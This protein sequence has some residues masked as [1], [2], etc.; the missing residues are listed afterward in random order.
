MVLHEVQ[1]ATN[2]KVLSLLQR[3][4]YQPA[5]RSPLWHYTQFF[6]AEDQ[7][8]FCFHTKFFEIASLPLLPTQAETFH[9]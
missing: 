8:R 1:N 4:Q 3:E 7:T 2:K 6:L 5:L 9:D